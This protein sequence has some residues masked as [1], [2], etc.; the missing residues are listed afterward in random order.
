MEP[1]LQ[2]EGGDAMTAAQ[3]QRQALRSAAHLVAALVDRRFGAGRLTDE[4]RD[5]IGI[6]RGELDELGLLA[7]Y[8]QGDG[9]LAAWNPA[10]DNRGSEVL[11][12]ASS[13]HS[14]PAELTELP[15]H[16]VV[17]PL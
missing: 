11:G 17:F 5:C 3:L 8:R 12:R 1:G 2:T 6:L 16:R 10:D 4:L 7:E 13:K 14:K 15:A 9:S